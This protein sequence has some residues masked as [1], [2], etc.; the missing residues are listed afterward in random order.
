MKKYTNSWFKGWNRDRAK[1]KYG[2]ENYY[3]A[4]NLRLNDRTAGSTLDLTTIDGNELTNSIDSNYRLYAYTVL[5]ESVYLLAIHNLKASVTDLARP[6]KLY[7]F[8]VA[9]TGHLVL[10]DYAGS[11]TTDALYTGDLGLIP[12]S[13]TKKI[14]G[15][16]E[17]PLIQKI[18]WTSGEAIR[19]ANVVVDLTGYT[20]TQFNII[21]SSIPGTITTN[22]VGLGTL[23]SGVVQYS[24]QL[25]NLNGASTSFAA[26]SDLIPL[27]VSSQT[28]IPD[29]DF[30]GSSSEESANK[31]VTFTISGIDSTNFNRIKIVRIF[32]TSLLLEP[33]I[34]YIADIN[35]NTTISYTDTGTDNL[36][37][38]TLDEYNFI[39]YQFN[40]STLETKNNILFAGGV[41]EQTYD[42]IWDSRAYRFNY[43][44]VSLL[45]TST[46]IGPLLGEVTS[47]NLTSIPLDHDCYNKYKNDITYD[48]F[49]ASNAIFNFKYKWDGVTI[50]AQGINVEID[51]NTDIVNLDDTLNDPQYTVSANSRNSNSVKNGVY[52]FY[53]RDEIYTFAIE[54]LNNKGQFSPAKWVCDFRMPSAND[55]IT[56]TN[57][58]VATN[59]YGIGLYL[60]FTIKNLPSDCIGYRI[61]RCERTAQDRTIL[62]QGILDCAVTSI[63]PSTDPRRPGSTLVSVKE[64]KGLTS[65]HHVGDIFQILD[66]SVLQ[67]YSPEISFNKNLQYIAGDYIEIIGTISR[68][69]HFTKTSL[70]T[71][72]VLQ[73]DSYSYNYSTSINIKKLTAFSPL[74]K[75]KITMSAG[76]LVN[77]PIYRSDSFNDKQFSVNIGGIDY[78]N[79]SQYNY[80]GTDNN[81]L[82]RGNTKFVLKTP[83]TIDLSTVSDTLGNGIKYIYFNYRRPT[84]Q[85]GGNSYQNRMNRTYIPC[86]SFVPKTGISNVTNIYNGDIF[87]DYFEC[88]RA[89]TFGLDVEASVGYTNDENMFETICFPVE[90]TIHVKWA[91]YETFNKNCL[92]PNSWLLQESAG[93][94]TKV[95]GTTTYK[96]QQDKD[97]YSYNSVYSI[98]NSATKV[99]PKNDLVS[100]NKSFDSRIQWSDRKFNGE[101]IDSWTIWKPLNFKDVDNQYGA[102]QELINY[103]TK[104][105]FFQ[106][107]GVGVL[108]VDERELTSG[109]NSSQLILGTGSVGQRYDYISTACGTIHSD[110]IIPC[111]AGIFWY[112]RY[113]NSFFVYEPTGNI[114]N[115]SKLSGI[116]SYLYENINDDSN[117]TN[118]ITGYDPKFNEVI[119][120]FKTN[121]NWGFNK[122]TIVYNELGKYFVGTFS[123]QPQYYINVPNFYYSTNDLIDIYKHNE[124][125]IGMDKCT[126]YG[127]TYYAIL[128][129]IVNPEG[130]NIVRFDILEWTSECVDTVDHNNVTFIRIGANNDYTNISN[131]AYIGLN[132]GT[133]QL[134]PSN[135]MQRFR[136]YRFNQLRDVNTIERMKDYYLK[137]RF[138]YDNTVVPTAT[139]KMHNLTTTYEHIAPY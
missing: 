102:I 18:Y 100:P 39:N 38:I 101:N 76:R 23:K 78:V 71:P 96:W 64:Y 37:S 9:T 35:S 137:I 86:T 32:Y 77:P 45:Y 28:I 11:I 133:I 60:I 47:G 128:E 49:V 15:R 70:T 109:T 19:F 22:S 56:Y 40:A 103:N 52:M 93:L 14:I 126:F 114:D 6:D 118:V 105:L 26:T 4:E 27:S 48:T 50:G 12:N 63:N 29:T 134:T 79:S 69:K 7:R 104:L 115:V 21:P 125:S 34:T 24:Y 122:K 10:A 41:V 72:F 138:I 75:Q 108:S 111:K 16:Y 3:Y 98:N 94:H 8:I 51:V 65:N 123:F 124:V 132:T 127:V 136:T 46:G 139:F 62:A 42:P 130:D 80:D 31:S 20:S 106:P 53:Q 66:K 90:S 112:D 99:Y 30:L 97:N 61:V 67:L 89:S 43:D 54:L 121:D 91:N 84:I 110:S 5:R 1:N 92:K 119:F 44:G 2:N 83:D 36:G 25:Y 85:Y 73:G 116:Q 87:I 74:T 113:N 131:M 17:N 81:G 95:I 117:L 57:S 58:L 59:L 135:M 120:T 55:S 33:T 82:G 129:A 88:N 107:T 68:N 13:S